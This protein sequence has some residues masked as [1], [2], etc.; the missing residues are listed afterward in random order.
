MKK[1]EVIDNLK[2]L[3]FQHKN[4]KYLTGK[5]VKRIPKLSYYIFVHFRTL[6]N[7]LRAAGLPSSKLAAAMN[8]SDEDLLS[9]LKNLQSKLGY[10]PKVWDI[11]RDE[12]LYKKYSDEKIIWSL[13]KSRF[14]GLIKAKE[15]AGMKENKRGAYK[16]RTAGENFEEGEEVL[17]KNRYWGAAAELHVLAELL[18]HEFQAANIPVDVG[19]DILAVKNNKT[20]YFQ[21]KHKDLSDSR[22]I[23][24]T[25]SSFEKTGSGNV[26]YIF[27]LLS[28]NKRDFLI[29]PYHIVNQW[30]KQGFAKEEESNYLIYI[31]KKDGKYKL[32]EV[33]LD[34]YL[35]NWKDIR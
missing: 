33:E 18:Y 11:Q 7:A 4:K 14:G 24:L 12:E 1:Q 23:K 35:D 15:F 34:N 13:Y 27:V 28:D 3:A 32:K 20:F 31:D 25:K 19:L 22:A 21:V 2:K 30:I 8:I 29:I 17:P 10:S 6:G 9:Y 26:Y 5:E 16:T